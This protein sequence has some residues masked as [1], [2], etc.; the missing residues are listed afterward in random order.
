MFLILCLC[1]SKN[2]LFGRCT[3]KPV[4]QPGPEIV[5]SH[6]VELDVE[7]VV[8]KENLPDQ[9]KLCARANFWLLLLLSIY[10]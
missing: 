2:V 4:I 9:V 5:T 8:D 3:G 1:L 10:A 6:W 7:D